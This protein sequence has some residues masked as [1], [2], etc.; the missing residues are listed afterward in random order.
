[1]YFYSKT[2]IQIIKQKLIGLLYELLSLQ[3]VRL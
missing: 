1:M 2:R 3:V